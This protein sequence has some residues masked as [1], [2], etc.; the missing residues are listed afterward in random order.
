MIKDIQKPSFLKDILLTVQQQM[1]QRIFDEGKTADSQPI[2]QYSE[3]YIQRR[4]KR[5]LG[6][7]KKV[8]ATFTGQMRNDFQLIQDGD[9]FSFGFTNTANGEKSFFVED[10]YKKAIFDL[11]DSEERLLGD[12][13][14]EKLNRITIDG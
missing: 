2:G 4:E 10:T 3:P 8:I 7:S 12:L 6:T 9:E 14:D 13:I 11:T 1:T 5:G